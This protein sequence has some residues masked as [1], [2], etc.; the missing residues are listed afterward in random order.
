ML[1]C[2]NFSTRGDAASSKNSNFQRY[3]QQYAA[4]EQ[5]TNVLHRY[6]HQDKQKQSSQNQI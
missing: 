5:A 2:L 4:A 1:F 6:Q 3:A